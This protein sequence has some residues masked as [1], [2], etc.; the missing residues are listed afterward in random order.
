MSHPARRQPLKA[1]LAVAVSIGMALTVA[2]W[3]GLW[4]AGLSFIVVIASVHGFLFPVWYRVTDEAIVIQTFFGRQQRPWSTLRRADP[5]RNG[6]HLSPFSTPS[7][8]DGTRGIYVRYG[9]DNRDEVV[10]AIKGMIEAAHEKGAPAV[11]ES[12]P[13][14]EPSRE[15]ASSGS[16]AQDVVH[17]RAAMRSV[18]GGTATEGRS[19]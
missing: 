14:D 1:A 4:L 5:G 18:L 13:G 10:A 3:A 9:D 7:W 17:S 19:P 6:V 16:K 11:R 2:S 12:A 15:V 8:L